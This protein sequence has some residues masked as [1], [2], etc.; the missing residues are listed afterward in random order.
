[1]RK[2]VVDNHD[3]KK[4]SGSSDTSNHTMVLNEELATTKAKL[5]SLREHV[6]DIGKT[7]IS[8]ADAGTAADGNKSF[9]E[10]VPRRYRRQV[11]VSSRTPE[12]DAIQSISVV[13]GTGGNIS[14]NNK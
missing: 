4:E 6:I 11:H 12:S 14:D 8:A 9:T 3:N 10:V 5:A 1:M 7:L 13:I 2:Y